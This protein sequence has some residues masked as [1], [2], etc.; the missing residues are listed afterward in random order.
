LKQSFDLYLKVLFYHSSIPV[1]HT[2]SAYFRAAHGPGDSAPGQYADCHD[3][4]HIHLDLSD[5]EGI[6][7]TGKCK[8]QYRF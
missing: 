3:G 7:E 5:T 4:Q 2:F 8:L 6:S 1:F